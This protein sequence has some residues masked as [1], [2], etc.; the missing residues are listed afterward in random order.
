[1]ILETSSEEE[2][3]KFAASLA[4]NAVPGTVICLDGE[5]GTGK[6]VFAKGFAEGLGIT[7]PVVSPTFT[8]LHGYEGGRMPFWH[9]DVYRITDVSEMD[10]IGYEDCFYGNGVSL[11]EWAAQVEEI[12][13]ENA[14]WIRI[15]KDADRGDDFRRITL[16]GPKKDETGCRES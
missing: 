15:E 1:M 11:I 5:L 14:I 13:P 3:K 7:E 2:T 12:I 9:F 6:T 10:E 8:I 4:K 16:T